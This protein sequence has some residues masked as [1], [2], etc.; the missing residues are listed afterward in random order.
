MDWRQPIILNNSNNGF[1]K[2]EI[3]FVVVA[4][5]IL[6]IVPITNFKNAEASARDARRKADLRQIFNA[7]DAYYQ[8]NQEYPLSSKNGRILGCTCETKT[9]E[10]CHWRAN[11]G[12]PRE[13]CDVNNIVYLKEI[14]GDPVGKTEYCYK[15][16]GKSFALYAKLE[17]DSDYQAFPN[18]VLKKCNNIDYNYGVSSLNIS[19]M[20]Y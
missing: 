2:G 9:P 11:T 5:G 14:L 19:P 16:D 6:A 12:G 18:G 13:F 10:A 8:Q 4:L 3:I 7:M 17:I 20:D 1:T 15:S